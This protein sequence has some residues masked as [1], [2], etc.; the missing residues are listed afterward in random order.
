[1]YE[2]ETDTMHLTEVP[3]FSG[4]TEDRPE[5]WEDGWYA[6]RIVPTRTINSRDGNTLTFATE[7]TLSRGGD[8]RNIRLQM[9]LHRKSDGRALSTNH[10]VNYRVEDLTGEIVKAVLARK[11]SIK[12]AAQS[13]ERLEWGQLFRAFMGI[14]RL[15]TLQRIAGIRRFETLPQGG[16]DLRPLFNKA[17]FVRLGD[18]DEG[19]YKEIKEI[20]DVPPKKASDLL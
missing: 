20:S 15:G 19:K 9:S 3:D 11:E 7:D 17:C 10:N 8:S 12:A 18:D 14:T 13:G 1:M 16:F 6:A 5:A 4:I 2:A